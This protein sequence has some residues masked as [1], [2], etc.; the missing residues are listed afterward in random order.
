M[1]NGHKRMMDTIA[2]Q[3]ASGLF[4]G[5]DASQTE[6]FIECEKIAA[7]EGCSLKEAVVIFNARCQAAADAVGESA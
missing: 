4:P 5:N 1:M 7:K 6:R 2:R 3:K